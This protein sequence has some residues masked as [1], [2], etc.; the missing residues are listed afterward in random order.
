MSKNRDLIQILIIITIGMF[1]PFITSIGLV[2]GF[3][4]SNILVT[5]GYFILV[6]GIELG[7]VYGYFFISNWLAIKK[8]DKIKPK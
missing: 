1:I 5:F 6:F 8:L 3:Y 7:V 2:Y 4:I